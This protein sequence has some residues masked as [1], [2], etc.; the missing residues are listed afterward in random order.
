MSAK[1]THQHHRIEFQKKKLNSQEKQIK[2]QQD[3]IL[4]FLKENS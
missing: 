3:K 1:T 2:E 4:K